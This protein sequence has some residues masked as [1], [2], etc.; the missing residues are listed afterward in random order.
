MNWTDGSEGLPS[1]YELRIRN[2]E[3]ARLRYSFICFLV[4]ILNVNITA[5]SQGGSVSPAPV[6]KNM[7]YRVSALNGI[8]VELRNG[9]FENATHTIKVSMLLDPAI[10]DLNGDGVDDALVLLSSNNSGSGTIIEAVALIAKDGVLTQYT[11]LILGDRWRIGALFFE[12][13]AGI[14][15]VLIHSDADAQC[16]PSVPAVA[17]LTL[18]NDSLRLKLTAQLPVHFYQCL[19]DDPLWTCRIGKD[20]SEFVTAEFHSQLKF[21]SQEINGDTVRSEFLDE[22]GLPVKAIITPGPC[23]NGM[24]ADPYPYRVLVK[25]RGKEYHGC[26][27]K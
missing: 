4:F 24:S 22:D 6:L 21:V 25:I 20:S 18:Q 8:T 10:G 9:N 12:K 23:A 1:N 19:G 27:K 2:L 16:C 26:G 17:G 7:T 3:L 15:D 13:G 11:S 5:F 14:L